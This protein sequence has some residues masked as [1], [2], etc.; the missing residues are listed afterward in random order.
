M[1]GGAFH[2]MGIKE[3]RQIWKK[4]SSLFLIILKLEK[5]MRHLRIE[6]LEVQNRVWSPGK[7][8]GAEDKKWTV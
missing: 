4:K 8:F 2:E 1:S 6:E 7:K 3:R 5:A